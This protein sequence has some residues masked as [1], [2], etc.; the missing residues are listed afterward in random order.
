MVY[1]KEYFENRVACMLDK[2]KN[3]IDYT[4]LDE[5]DLQ[6]E[7]SFLIMQSVTFIVFDLFRLYIKIDPSNY[8]LYFD[9]QEIVDTILFCMMAEKQ[10]NLD[11]DKNKYKKCCFSK[12]K[13]S[14]VELKEKRKDLIEFFGSDIPFFN[15]Y[16]EINELKRNNTVKKQ[17]YIS[18]FIYL[19]LLTLCHSLH[20]NFNEIN[21]FTFL[22]KIYTEIVVNLKNITLT[23][24]E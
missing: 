3:K 9:I 18:N 14:L 13:K 7:L 17:M 12:D 20:Y 6:I 4:S 22:N 5:K 23:F 24:E 10:F 19:L 1:N 21:L 16:K 15:Q 2:I 8:K 11:I